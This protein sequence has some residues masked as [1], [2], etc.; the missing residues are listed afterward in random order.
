ML[1]MGVHWKVDTVGECM[2]ICRR[3]DVY[4]GWTQRG[5]HVHRGCLQGCTHWSVNMSDIK[6]GHFDKMKVSGAMHA[7][8]NS[9]ADRLKFMVESK[10]IRLQSTQTSFGHGT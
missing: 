7:F 1:W 2:G 8:S 9:M 4:R 5:V 3:G 10:C 6:P